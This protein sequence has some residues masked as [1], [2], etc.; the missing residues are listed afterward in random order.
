MG[1]N[2]ITP[3]AKSASLNT[4]AKISK[5]TGICSKIRDLIKKIINLFARCIDSLRA[6]FPGTVGKLQQ[7]NKYLE[8][9]IAALEEEK[10]RLLLKGQESAI[11]IIA[12]NTPKQR[13]ASMSLPSTVFVL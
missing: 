1:V 9:K 5:E 13:S 4:T 10:R 2:K 3:V 7:K 6:Y 12:S 11:K 8:E